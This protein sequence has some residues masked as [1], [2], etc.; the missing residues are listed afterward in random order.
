MPSGL[1]PDLV[2]RRVCPIAEPRH[3]FGERQRRAFGIGEIRGS[4]H[5]ATSMGLWRCSI[6]T[7]CSEPIAL[8]RLQVGLRSA[9]RE[10]GPRAQSP[11]RELFGAHNLRSSMERWDSYQ[12]LA[13]GC[14]G[15][16]L[17]HLRL[18]AT[19]PSCGAPKKTISK[20]VDLPTFKRRMVEDE[21]PNSKTKGDYK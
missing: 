4:R 19:P 3:G 16:S 14:P 1:V 20:A 18:F 13:E 7:L 6:Q 12:L 10:R 5:A 2:R 9:V 11:S 15:Y 21:I 8:P 17:S